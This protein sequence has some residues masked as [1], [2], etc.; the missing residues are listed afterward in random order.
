MFYEINVAYES[1]YAAAKDNLEKYDF[2]QSFTI[3]IIK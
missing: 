3:N 2:A 1:W